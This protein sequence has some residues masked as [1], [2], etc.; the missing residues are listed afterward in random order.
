MLEK[1]AVCLVVVARR[2]VKNT[3]NTPDYILQAHSNIASL[4]L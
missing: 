3:K 1:R 2:V 4:R